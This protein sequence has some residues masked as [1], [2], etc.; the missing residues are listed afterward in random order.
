MLTKSNHLEK[1]VPPVTAAMDKNETPTERIERK[2]HEQA[3][4]QQN[5]K[6]EAQWR[7]L[8]SHINGILII[9]AQWSLG[10]KPNFRKDK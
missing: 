8:V 6:K 9:L 3:L 4:R 2:K 10:Y 7:A 5:P 1:G